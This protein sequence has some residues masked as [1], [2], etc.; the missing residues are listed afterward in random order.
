M[1]YLMRSLEKTLILW[2]K[3]LEL[4]L[5]PYSEVG[6]TRLKTKCKKV[7]LYDYIIKY[8][9]IFICSRGRRGHQKLTPKDKKY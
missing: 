6:S 3:I 9:R 2:R 5:I 8:R 4:Y 7:K 1:G